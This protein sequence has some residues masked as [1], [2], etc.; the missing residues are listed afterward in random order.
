MRKSTFCWLGLLAVLAVTGEPIARGQA[1]TF[2]LYRDYLIVARGTAGPL[3]GLNFMVDTGAN[4]SVLDRRVAQK[5]HLP[6]S[7]VSIAVVA[8]SVAAGQSVVPKLGLGPLHRENLPVLVED[9]GFFQKAFP[10]RIDGIIGLDL[11]GQSSFVIDYRAREIRFGLSPVLTTSLPLRIKDGLPIV[12][13]V[14]NS[15]SVHLLFDTGAASL[16]LFGPSQPR[17]MKISVAI[18]EFDRK[19]VWLQSLKLGAADFGREAAFLVQRRGDGR[20]DFDGLMSPAALGITKVAIDLGRGE[21]GFT[22]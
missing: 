1:V 16:I 15:T 4:P 11:L 14:L 10:V 9:L 2:D 18:G 17:P 21:L 19:Q 12:D 13:A 20:Q 8:G 6:E 7:P 5:L 22:R 3:K